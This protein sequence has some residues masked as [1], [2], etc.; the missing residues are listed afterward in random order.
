MLSLT[1]GLVMSRDRTSPSAL[2]VAVIGGGIGGLTAAVA[3]RRTGHDVR[4]FEQSGLRSE[5]GAGIQL[6]PNCTRILDRLGLLPAVRR[7]AFRPTAFEFRRWDDGRLLSSTPLGDAIE[8]S[9]GAPYLHVHRADLVS[10][11]AAALPAD[12]IVT[13]RRCAGVSGGRP[14]GRARV[15]FADGA[16][17]IAD[18]VVGADGIHSTV[19]EH[20]FGPQDARFLGHV[21]YRGLIPAA[22]VAHLDLE[23][24]C[25]VRLGPGAH[26]VHYYVGAGR[27]LNVVCVVEER[28]WTR[29]SWTDR[30]DVAELRAAFAGWHPV[31]AGIVDALDAP[32]KWALLDRAPLPAWSRGAVTL[33]GD[34]AHPMLPFGAQGA[35]QAIEDAAVLAG[36]LA[37]GDRHRVPAA[38]AVYECRRRDR[39][40]RVQEMSL[41]NGQRF[42]LPDG[43]SQQ[44]RDAA[45]SASFGLSPEIDWL[46]GHDAVGA[47]LVDADRGAS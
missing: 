19:R 20:L 38:L 34:A 4:V 39:T 43:L 7:V 32:L 40:A 1:R 44:A 18:V 11:L 45:M 24:R 10:V 13:G 9:Y 41:R 14:G 31:V 15:H 21:A 5:V 2:S 33:L 22:R 3:L 36:C 46:Y 30:G 37:G 47:S 35:A 12:R 42:H 23:P 29:E 16:D 17:T 26:L 8:R 27:Q 6:A 25:T 28:T